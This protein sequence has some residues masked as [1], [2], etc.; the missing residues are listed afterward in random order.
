M[1]HE[2]EPIFSQQGV[3][4]LNLAQIH[5]SPFPLPATHGSLQMV[6]HQSKL[7]DGMLV[8]KHISKWSDIMHNHRDVEF[9]LFIIRVKNEST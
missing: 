2:S 7:V 6:D 1:L 9:N 4:L 8:H 5:T 3:V